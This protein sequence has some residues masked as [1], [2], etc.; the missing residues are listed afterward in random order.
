MTNPDL[1]QDGR[2]SF[3]R[4]HSF[5]RGWKHGSAGSAED[6][7]FAKARAH[8]FKEYTDGYERG[9]KDRRALHVEISQRTGYVPNPLRET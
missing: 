4:Y 5:M 3:E 6:P 7:S 2:E 1:E 8:L 9:R